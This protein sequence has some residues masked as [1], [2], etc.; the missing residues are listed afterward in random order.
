MKENLCFKIEGRD[1]FLEHVL[2]ELDYIPIFYICKD[3]ESNKYVVMCIDIDEETYV[4][5]RTSNSK[6]L[7]ML[8]GIITM[9]KIVLTASDF[10]EVIAA[11][12]FE[13]DEVKKISVSA[14]SEDILPIE[15]S[16]YEIDK[17]DESE[18]KEYVN[19]LEIALYSGN[20][21]IKK[22]NFNVDN[23]YE[24]IDSSI[25]HKSSFEMKDITLHDNRI[26]KIIESD[27]ME[28]DLS[29]GEN[30]LNIDSYY[31][32]NSNHMVSKALDVNNTHN[33]NDC[34][35]NNQLAAA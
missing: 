20:Q 9:R 2:V 32:S 29:I 27:V 21:T 7:D 14:I 18:I 1:L 5:A 25:L 4:V 26:S 8:R 13:D 15:N 24:I 3:R 31:K 12:N 17:S 10:W 28:V 22:L 11:D 16:Y 6:I 34:S 30:N 23:F 35:F 19:E 33:E